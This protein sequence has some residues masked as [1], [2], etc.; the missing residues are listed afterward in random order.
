MFEEIKWEYVAGVNNTG[1]DDERIVAGVEGNETH[2]F[3]TAYGGLKRVTIG[4]VL[5]FNDKADESGMQ[6]EV[7]HNITESW[8]AAVGILVNGSPDTLVISEMGECAL[9]SDLMTGS[10]SR[11]YSV[12]ESEE[13]DADTM[14]EVDAN[15]LKMFDFCNEQ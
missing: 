15:L 6:E 13:Y 14:G 5:I 1:D 9:L 10:E 3:F 2:I 11:L 8:E 7:D 12:S 4:Q